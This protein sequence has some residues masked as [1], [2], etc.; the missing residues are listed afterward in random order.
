M[1]VHQ[2]LVRGVFHAHLMRL[3]AFGHDETRVHGGDVLI[4]AQ[5]FSH[6]GVR[7]ECGRSRAR[8]EATSSFFGQEFDFAWRLARGAVA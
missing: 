2:E 3:G 1:G 6:G 7:S 5:E 8:G 4:P